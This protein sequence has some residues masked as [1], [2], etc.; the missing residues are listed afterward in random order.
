[1]YGTP[2]RDIDI[3]KESYSTMNGSRVCLWIQPLVD[4]KIA[5][6]W[7]LNTLSHS[8]FAPNI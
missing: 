6:K 2:K 1:M 4:A 7:V 5:N 3:E 8:D